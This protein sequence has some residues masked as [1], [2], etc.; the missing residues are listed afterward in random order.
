MLI[1]KILGFILLSVAALVLMLLLL[2]LFVPVRYSG[3]IKKSDKEVLGSGKI[4]WLLGLVCVKIKYADKSI[5]KEGRIAF[6]K[7]WKP[8]PA[9][10]KAEEKPDTAEN[11]PDTADNKTESSSLSINKK[12]ITAVDNRDGTKDKKTDKRRNKKT[13]KTRRK[14]SK[15][16]KTSA[17]GIIDRLKNIWLNRDKIEMIL[18]ENHDEI[19]KALRRIKKLLIHI[20]PQKIVGEAE[21]GFDDPSVTGKVLGVVSALYAC[22]GPLLVLKPDFENKIFDI[23]VRFKGR[24]RIFTVALIAVLLYFNKELKNAGKQL[25]ELSEG[26]KEKKDG[27]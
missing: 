5:I 24:I 27:R 10:K 21:F 1:L 12:E 23:D 17:P 2:V 19:V 7:L 22:M 18:D 4:T 8:K 25:K 16:N 3:E 6:Y 11:K 26:A 20:L 14:K 15:K 9:A 13:V